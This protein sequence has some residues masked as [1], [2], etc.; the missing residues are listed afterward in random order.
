VCSGD[1]QAGVPPETASRVWEKASESVQEAKAAQTAGGIVMN[2]NA[3]GLDIAVDQVLQMHLAQGTQIWIASSI[4]RAIPE[5][6]LPARRASSSN[7]NGAYTSA[8]RPGTGWRRR[9]EWPSCPAAYR[10]A[11]TRF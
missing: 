8:K 10:A 5:I 2:K 11:Q 9:R 4:K 1:I 6:A 7:E 3:A